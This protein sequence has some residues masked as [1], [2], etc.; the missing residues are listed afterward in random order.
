MDPLPHCTCGA[1]KAL[2]NITNRNILMQFFIGL[3][4]GYDQVR[5]QNLLLNPFPTIN[6]AYL[7]IL[8]VK[9]QR[10]ASSSFNDMENGS[11]LLTRFTYS[12]KDSSKSKT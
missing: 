2:A 6:K 8:Q 3:Y 7:I 5:D 4:D 1:T 9:S 12:K 10:Q 11:T